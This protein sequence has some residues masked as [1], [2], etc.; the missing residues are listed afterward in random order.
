MNIILFRMSDQ[1][2][3]STQSNASGLINL[4]SPPDVTPEKN[5]SGFRC[6]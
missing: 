6:D 1:T 2:P 4:V 3:F 5:F